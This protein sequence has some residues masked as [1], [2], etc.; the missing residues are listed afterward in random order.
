M[1]I[2]VEAH[3]RR[4]RDGVVRVYTSDSWT[5]AHEKWSKDEARRGKTR[6]LADSL[7]T[8]EYWWNE[9][10]GGCDCNRRIC[11]HEAG[12]DDY[13]PEPDEDEG[14]C[15]GGGRFDLNRLVAR[16]DDAGVNEEFELRTEPY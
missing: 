8:I 11:F 3:I 15:I 14:V 2:I 16:V 5:S 13:E 7:G 4:N 6:T 10:N 12:G 9:G 1:R